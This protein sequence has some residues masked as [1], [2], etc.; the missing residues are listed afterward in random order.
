M[1]KLK[2]F[3]GLALVVVVLI[4]MSSTALAAP[5]T[6][7]VTSTPS[8]PIVGKVQ[9]ISIKTDANNITSVDVTLIDLN[10]VTQSVTLSLADALAL[11]LVTL[12]ANN[13]PSVNTAMIGKTITIQPS[14][15]TPIVIENPVGAL[16]AGFFG[17]DYSVVDGFHTDGSG[18]GVIAQACWMSYELKGDASM[19]GDIIEAKKS[20]DYSAI[21]PDGTTATNWGQFMKAVS[22]NKG[23]KHNL[24]SIVSGHATPIITPTVMVSP[25]P[26]TATPTYNQPAQGNGNNGNGNAPGRSKYHGRGGDNGNGKGPK[27]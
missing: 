18:Y 7:P 8:A 9:S 19:C 26:T 3:A 6:E 23:T 21:L 5:T 24:G 14:V 2:M 17:L 15:P 16:I 20:G 1:L 10:G 22:E 13:V 27:K 11:G 12:D 4:A 25:V